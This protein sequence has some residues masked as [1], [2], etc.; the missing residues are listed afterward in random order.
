[1]LMDMNFKIRAKSESVA[2]FTKSVLI[3]VL[4]KYGWG[5]LG[6]AFAQLA[7]GLVLIFMYY[8]QSTD[9]Q[10][11]TIEHAVGITS[12]ENDDNSDH[13]K[14]V[15]SFTTQMI[16]TMLRFEDNVLL[17]HYTDLIE[18]SKVCF[19]KFILSEGQNLMIVYFT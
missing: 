3:F 12:K 16:S 19:L 4:I 10:I 7:Y 2:I 6:Y 1:M 15:W 11:I 17:Q 5:L 13:A 8:S 18:F 14:D 9:D